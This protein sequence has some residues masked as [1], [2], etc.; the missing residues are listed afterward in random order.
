MAIP[1]NLLAGVQKLRVAVPAK[2]FALSR[3]FYETVGF[4]TTTVAPNLTEIRL[5]PHM[6]FLQDYY[7]KEWAGN[8]V[9]HLTVDDSEPWWKH[10]EPLKLPETFGVRA[11]LPPKVMPWGLKVVHLFDPAGVM[12]MIASPPG[13][14]LAEPR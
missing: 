9:F 1:D 4:E 13:P 8:F 12:W 11:P 7:Q 2:D 6:F 14:P 5:G 10:I 3:R